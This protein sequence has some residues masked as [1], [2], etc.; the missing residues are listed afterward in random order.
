MWEKSR[1][2]GTLKHKGNVF[3]LAEAPLGICC[4]SSG[5]GFPGAHLPGCTE[6]GTTFPSKDQTWDGGW[7]GELEVGW[8]LLLESL[9]GGSKGRGRV[10][11]ALS[12][13][14]KTFSGVAT[15]VPWLSPEAAPRTCWLGG[16]THQLMGLS[17]CSAGDIV[18]FTLCSAS[19]SPW[20]PRLKYKKKQMSSHVDI[21]AGMPVNEEI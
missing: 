5:Q 13:F 19:R 20:H 1:L 17:T 6:A 7:G 3:H 2:T 10:R 21:S 14:L 4:C 8:R 18:G 11:V 12:A 9:L 15:S 16:Q